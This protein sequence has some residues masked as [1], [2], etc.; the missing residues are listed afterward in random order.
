MALSS[1]RGFDL[2]SAIDSMN[3]MLEAE[4][5]KEK[6]YTDI[7]DW[8]DNGGVD[9]EAF[10]VIFTQQQRVVLKTFYGLD[11]TDEELSILQYWATDRV[12]AEEVGRTTFDF[13]LG[14]TPRQFMV[15]EVG[16]RG[17]KCRSLNSMTVCPEQGMMYE[18]EV[19][20]KLMGIKQGSTLLTLEGVKEFAINNNMVDQTLDYVETVAIE[21][22]SKTAQTNAFYVK[23][24]SNTKKITTS[25][26]Y[27]LEATPEHRIK[28]MNTDGEIVWRYFSDLQEGDYVC[29][30][31]NTNLFTTDYI[32]LIDHQ[33]NAL[34]WNK[35]ARQVTIPEDLLLDTGY[36]YLLGLLT[37]NGSWTSA[38]GLQLTHHTQDAN[39]YMATMLVCMEPLGLADCVYSKVKSQNG[40]QT[41][42]NSKNL[43]KLFDNL[44]FTI[45]SRVNKKKTPW[46]IRMSPKDVQAAYL[47]GL[48]DGDGTVTKGG[49]SVEFC[50]ASKQLAEETQLLLLNFGIVSTVRAKYVNEV[51][52]YKLTLRGQRSVRR[53]VE[54]IG[55]RLQRKQQQVLNSLA[56]SSRDGGD[57]ERIPYQLDWLQRVCKSLPDNTGMQPGSHHAAGHLLGSDYKWGTAPLQNLKGEFRALCGNSIKPSSGELLSSYRLDKLI[58]F[59]EEFCEDQEWIDHF[60]HIQDCDY[61]YDPIVS[62]E[63]SESFCVDLSVPGCNQYVSQGMTNHNSLLGSIV[64]VYEF[65]LLCRMKH[66]QRELNIASSSV[67]SFLMLASSATQANETIFAYVKGMLEYVPYIKKL[68]DK[69]Y[70]EVLEEEIRYPTKRIKI[71][72]GNSKAESQVGGN[73]Y[74]LVLDEAAMFKSKNGENNAL[75][76]WDELG[77]GGAPFGHKHKRIAISSA[78]YY[79]DAMVRLYESASQSQ[80]WI[81]FRLKSWQVNPIHGARDNPII[82]AVYIRDFKKAQLLF[83]GIRSAAVNSFFDVD[84]VNK[85]FNI[86]T[87]L[88]AKELPTESDRL[89]RLEI[90]SMSNLE[91]YFV[92]H[93]DPASVSDS[94]GLAFGHCSVIEGFKHVFIDGILAWV[95]KPDCPVSFMN[96]SNIVCE[97]GD[98]VPIAKLTSDGKETTE[99]FQRFKSLGWNVDTTSVANAHQYATYETVRTLMNEGRL[100]LPKNSPWTNKLKSELMNIELINNNKITHGADGKDIADCVAEVCFQLVGSVSAALPPFSTSFFKRNQSSPFENNAGSDNTYSSIFPFPVET[101]K[102][103]SLLSAAQNKRGVLQDIRANKSS[104]LNHKP[105]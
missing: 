60:K 95:P 81:G 31:R 49:R 14:L 3:I 105:I 40:T 16:R 58:P 51:P 80:A 61:F 83:E 13:E 67:I 70:I 99:M 38:A 75:R 54:E 71:I 23:G 18:Y 84:A 33:A 66:P 53:F 27:N 86:N 52:Y 56:K 55:F 65:E 42:C 93:L 39:T 102:A 92:M 69:G 77:A 85:A 20:G 64:A 79:N 30:H 44:G 11:L 8:F 6:A 28:V 4:F 15:L 2:D 17:S 21:G 26:G 103:F 50:S 59:L 101:N 25:C 94:F 45:E 47:S 1:G 32:K 35:S 57:T 68:I 76:L 91:G 34:D 48:F 72:S 12:N 88:Y 22:K 100:H 104:R 73:V 36:G 10:G 63:D 9:K 89:T 29:V 37:A 7:L 24:I 98:Y 41:A 74:M 5:V 78:G 90:I 62:V 97:I 19:L 46:S 43:R 87:K 96:V 82:D